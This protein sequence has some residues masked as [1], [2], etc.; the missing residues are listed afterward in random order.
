MNRL[1]FLSV[2]VV[3]LVGALVLTLGV[4]ATA[5]NR[6]A[7]ESSE[8]WTPERLADG[9]P[10]ISGMWNNSNAMFTPLELPAELGEA[11]APRGDDLLARRDAR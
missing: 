10:N 3:A 6:S 9:Q 8:T 4:P 1:I 11:E 5:Q 2:A 7:A